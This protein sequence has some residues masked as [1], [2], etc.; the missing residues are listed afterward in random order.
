[1]LE[2]VEKVVAWYPA[3]PLVKMPHAPGHR[4]AHLVGERLFRV[5]ATRSPLR[6]PGLAA[7][8]LRG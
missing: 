4:T 5:E 6:L 1:M 2:G 8:A 7:A 3:V